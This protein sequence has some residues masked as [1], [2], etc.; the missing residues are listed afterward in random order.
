MTHGVCFTPSAGEVPETA[1]AL[2]NQAGKLGNQWPAS[3]TS[4]LQKTR[5]TVPEERNLRLSSGL[6]AQA[7]IYAQAVTH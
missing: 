7:Q 3:L 6:D 1:G 5:Q 4:L 2:G